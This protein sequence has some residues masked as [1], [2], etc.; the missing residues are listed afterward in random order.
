MKP[1]E[2]RAKKLMKRDWKIRNYALKHNISL[3]RRLYRIN[4]EEGD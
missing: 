4:N 1:R 2:R 3:L